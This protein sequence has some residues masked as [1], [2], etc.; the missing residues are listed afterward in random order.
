MHIDHA[1]ARGYDFELWLCGKGFDENGKD[2][3]VQI[4]V[5]GH[6]DQ[7]LIRPFGEFVDVDVEPWFFDCPLKPFREMVGRKLL[8][9]VEHRP[10]VREGI[11]A[12]FAEEKYTA[13]HLPDLSRSFRHPA[14]EAFNP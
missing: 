9:D 6:G 13:L 10:A 12:G 8:V 14:D 2:S 1:E 7:H 4:F 11:T 3:E 5:L